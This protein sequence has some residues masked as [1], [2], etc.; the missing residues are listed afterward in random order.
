MSS[1]SF[2]RTNDERLRWFSSTH[3]AWSSRMVMFFRLTTY[4]LCAFMR[5]VV[6]IAWDCGPSVE[7]VRYSCGVDETRG[8]SF[9]HQK[10]LISEDAVSP[11][12]SLASLV[13]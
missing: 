7:G 10:S 9:A 12:Y 5:I 13:R 1:S 6:A 11:P 2:P 4:A 3:S 8:V